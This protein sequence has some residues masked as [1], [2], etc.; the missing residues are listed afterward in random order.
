MCPRYG[1]HQ[2]AYAY[3]ICSGQG[4]PGRPCPAEKSMAYRKRWARDASLTRD[5]GTRKPLKTIIRSGAPVAPQPSRPIKI[6]RG[7]CRFV[8]HEIPGAQRAELGLAHNKRWSLCLHPE[9]P[10]G[11]QYVCPCNGCGPNC[12]G[13]SPEEKPMPNPPRVKWAYGITTV[14]MRRDNTLLHRTLES[15]KKAGFDK[16]HLFVD[17]SDDSYSWKREFGLDIT[18]RFPKVR[19]YAH[20]MLSLAELYATNPDAQR[21]AI[22]QDDIVASLS[23]RSYLDRCPFPTKGYL[24]L[25][26]YPSNDPSIN[27]DLQVPVDHVGWYKSNQYGRGAQ[28]L[29]FDR[30]GVVT[31]LTR[32]YIVRRVEDVHRG[33]KAVDGGIVTALKEAGYT[34]YVHRP[35]LIFHTGKLS[36]MENRPQPDA[37]SFQG[38]AFDL[39]T[40]LRAEP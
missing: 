37:P 14:P 38:E 10:L 3:G 12:P 4:T 25:I 40:L 24:N 27:K 36:A 17:G 16:P 21:F 33:W 39:L 26:T 35:S 23:L 11:A 13:Y 6:H 30:D 20:W 29:V 15:L 2:D 18:C 8:G 28:G 34:E 19:T 9:K 22:F 1:I 5:P 7:P 32:P 31:L